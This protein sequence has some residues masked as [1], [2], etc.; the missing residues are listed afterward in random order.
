MLSLC[1]FAPRH[2]QTVMSLAGS[3]SK[4]ISRFHLINEFISKSTTTY[5]NNIY[6]LI[7]KKDV[8]KLW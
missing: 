8:E 2:M 1:N 4:K 7:R 3:F 5:E 6:K